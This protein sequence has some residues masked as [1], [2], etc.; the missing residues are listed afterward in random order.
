MNGIIHPCCHPE[1]KA[2]PETEL[3]MMQVGKTLV[4]ATS[5]SGGTSCDYLTTRG[6][7]SPAI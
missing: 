1:D 7:A 2:E 3:E 6:L 4:L 5:L